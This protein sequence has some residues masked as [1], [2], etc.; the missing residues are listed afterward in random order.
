MQTGKLP[1]VSAETML[2]DAIA[3][4]RES[5]RTGLV[6]LDNDRAVL[7]HAPDLFE[8]AAESEGLRMRDLASGTR[9]PHIAET[10]Q[11]IVGAAMFLG[12]EANAAI[13]KFTSNFL[14]TRLVVTQMYYCNKNPLNHYYDASEV[15]TLKVLGP[16]QWE[17]SRAD[18]GIVS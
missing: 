7:F 3:D 16:N 9:L 1:L 13:I 11:K 10:D 4:L 14:Y 8:A 12:Q 6:M 17:C 15:K 18:H 2:A 5:R